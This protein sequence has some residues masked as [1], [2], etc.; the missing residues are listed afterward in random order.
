[1]SVL[2]PVI[3]LL[4]LAAHIY[5]STCTIKPPFFSP[6]EP[7]FIWKSFALFLSVTSSFKSKGT[8]SKETW[9]TS[10]KQNHEKS[11]VIFLGCCFSL[12]MDGTGNG[13][14]WEELS[15]CLN[16]M[17]LLTF[18]LLILVCSIFHFLL[19]LFCFRL[20]VLYIRCNCVK[21]KPKQQKRNAKVG[22]KKKEDRFSHHCRPFIL[23][24]FISSLAPKKEES[25][26]VLLNLFV[27]LSST[28]QISVLFPTTSLLYL[29]F[30]WGITKEKGKNEELGS[31]QIGSQGKEWK[32]EEDGKKT[33]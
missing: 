13:N 8:M 31:R 16:W 20:S 2:Y 5:S 10:E 21:N 4:F 22:G 33:N 17:F 1:M 29:F 3:L 14:E 19:S 18:T 32:E 12:R 26:L 15:G 7:C 27:P 24:F 11:L 9:R 25:V 30:L 28:E 23:L 6:R